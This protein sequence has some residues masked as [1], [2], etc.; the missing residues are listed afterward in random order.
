MLHILLNRKKFV[1]LVAILAVILGNS[2]DKSIH[3]CHKSIFLSIIKYNFL[4]VNSL[5]LKDNS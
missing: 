2:F 1:Y 5:L 3:M 4:N